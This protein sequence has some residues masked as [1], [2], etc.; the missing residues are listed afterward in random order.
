MRRE[1]RRA[2]KEHIV[3]SSTTGVDLWGRLSN[4]V[5]RRLPEHDVDEIVSAY[6]DGLS[7]DSLAAQL[8]VHRTTIID[9]L[10]RRGIERRRVVRKM[11]DRSVRQAGKRYATGKSL[12]VVA[13]QF[14]IDAK[15]LAREFRQ[16]GVSIRPR[17]G[18]PR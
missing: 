15:T 14:G 3:V 10:D 8:C 6:L 13:H 7:I 12:K 1:V 4:P 17:Q 5:Q 11:T 16:A 18:W 9:H 2:I